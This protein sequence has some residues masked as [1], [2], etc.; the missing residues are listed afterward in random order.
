MI[1]FKNVTAKNFLSI[2]NNTQGINLDR[3]DLTL[4]LGEN[5]D[6]GG[7]DNGS[8]NGTGKTALLNA[9]SYAL[10]GQALSSIRKDNLINHT[11]GKGM[12]ITIEFEKNGQL[13]KIERGRKPNFITFYVGDKAVEA[14]DSDSQGD[15]R[16]TQAE[17]EKLL[18]MSHDMFKHV[19][20]LN[21]Y[22]EPFLSLKANDQRVIIEQLL[23]ITLLSEKADSLKEL[24]KAVKDEIT[25]E[26][27]NIKAITDANKRFQEQIEAL[28]RRQKL[29]LTKKEEDL[30][31]LRDAYD[32]LLNIDIESEIKTH[33]DLKEWIEKDAYLTQ[34]KKDAATLKAAI[35][36]EIVRVNKISKE[37]ESL[38]DHKCHSCGQE[39]HDSKHEELLARKEHDEA[40]IREH[41]IALQTERIALDAEIS[42]ITLPAKPETFYKKLEEALEHKSS[43]AHLKQQIDS[44]E[45]DADP[46]DEQ[47]NDMTSSGI[48]EVS[49]DKINELTKLKEHQD[50]LFKL[51]T[52][53]DSF[54]R[55]QIIN[56]NLTF[57]NKRLSYYL[58]KVG[59]PHQVVFQNDLT[60]EISELG[61][62]LDFDNLSRGERGRLILSLS[63][64][65]RDVWE[66]LYHPINLLFIDELID[67][68]L[69]TNGVEAALATLKK[70]ARDHNKS[71]WLV[72]HK[73]ELTNRVNNILNVVK[74]HGFTTYSNEIENV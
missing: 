20:A 69:D 10:Y 24:N 2:G 34:L 70:M 37:L 47:I 50:F 9:I 18:E 61:R 39:L 71:V 57:L 31:N 38:R 44:K 60:V 62:D 68:G 45:A 28:K 15:S 36:K 25:A 33:S 29:W 1:K 23:G 5:L 11:N 40:E 46:Y 14:Q 74:E 26:E 6:L 30:L 53:K 55:K 8:R 17:I 13:Y 64:A 41:I 67:N 35:D 63:W 27:I 32:L 3:R 66:S 48:V 56:Q 43:I 7:D 42:T 22:T 16:E 72:S 52:N 58:D 4:I 49:Y 51:L 73:D 54:I 12:V 65:F 59:L 21:T 19:V